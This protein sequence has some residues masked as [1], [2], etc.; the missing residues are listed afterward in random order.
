LCRA[1]ACQA[2]AQR[3]TGLD[4]D[5]AREL[6]GIGWSATDCKFG[7]ILAVKKVERWT[8]RILAVAVKVLAK[9]K[10][11]QIADL[12]PEIVRQ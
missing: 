8:S 2:A 10:A 11:T 1:A 3:L 9:Y 4:P 12:W 7:R 6:N 5:G